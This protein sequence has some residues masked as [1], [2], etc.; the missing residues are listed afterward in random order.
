MELTERDLVEIRTALEQPTL[1]QAIKMMEDTL[2]KLGYVNL[3]EERH[4]TRLGEAFSVIL[5]AF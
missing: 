4:A 3:N 1:R 5:G 2:K